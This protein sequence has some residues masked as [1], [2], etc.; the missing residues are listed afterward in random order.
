MEQGRR[1][2]KKKKSGRHRQQHQPKKTSS[3]K[4]NG[5]TPPTVTPPRSLSQQPGAHQQ[6]QQLTPPASRLGRFARR[7]DTPVLM[8]AGVRTETAGVFFHLNALAVVFCYVVFGL[9]LARSRIRLV[10]HHYEVKPSWM[11]IGLLLFTPFVVLMATFMTF[12]YAGGIGLIG[13][14][15]VGW[16]ADVSPKAPKWVQAPNANTPGQ[17]GLA[18]P[19]PPGIAPGVTKP[20]QL[21]GPPPVGAPV[22]KPPPLAGAVPP[23]P[24]PLSQKKDGDTHRQGDA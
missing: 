11:I 8:G 4:G 20:G 10:V 3:N 23:P 17:G 6:R 13:M 1:S 7:V 14:G 15:L 2:N 21:T 22:P 24:P 16:F 9:A 12:L 18:M 5:K 19:P